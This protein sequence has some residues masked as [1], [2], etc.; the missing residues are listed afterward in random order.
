MTF[1]RKLEKNMANAIHVKFL[2]K[3]VKY[4]G[5]GHWVANDGIN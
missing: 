3:Q 2:V 5:Q 1:D 4:Q